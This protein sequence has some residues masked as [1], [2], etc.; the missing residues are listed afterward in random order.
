M[1]KSP[2]AAFFLSLI[3]GAGHVYLGRP[4]RTIL[5]GGAFFGSLGLIFLLLVS[6]GDA[7]EVAIFLLIFAI[8]VWI[9]NMLDMI[10]T[11]LSGKLQAP[12]AGGG[13]YGG[14]P[15]AYAVADRYSYEAQREK[16]R[17]ILLSFLPGLGH[18]SLGLMQ[19]GITLLISFIGLFAIVVFLSIA[20]GSGA[21]LIFLLALPVIWIYGMFD[22]ISLQHAKQRGETIVDRAIFE[23]LERN[24]ASG[25]KNKVLAIALSIFPG[26]GHLYLGLQKRGLQLMGGFLLAIYIM[27]NLRLSLFFFLLPLF[28]CFAFFD[29][30]QQ[31]SRYERHELTDEPVMKQ[32]VPYQKWF[33]IALIGF[34][35]Y[36]LLNRVVTNFVLNHFTR[37]VYEAYMDFIYIIPTVAISFVLILLG[38]RMV[39]GGKTAEYRHNAPPAP[40][41]AGFAPTFDKR[42]GEPYER[43]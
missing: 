13:A 7:D 25:R 10:V 8:L 31:T 21:L 15:D 14:Y 28:W 36:Y 1:N 39:F 12:G 9:V 42:E 27:D 5:Y 23:D 16:T 26:A 3:P 33:G 41:E 22:A 37:Q 30:L 11:L 40:E 17:T 29:A 32:F 4:I 18:M 24:I 38:V 6:N 34:G 43:G 35:V 20:T 19:R 2:L